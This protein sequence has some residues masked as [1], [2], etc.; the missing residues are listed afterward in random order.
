MTRAADVVVAGLGVMGSAVAAELSR[1]GLRVVGLDPH[2]P[3]HRLGSSHGETRMIRQAYSEN[4]LYVPL[5]RRAYEAW[6]ELELRSGRRLLFETGGIV[7]GFP[8]GDLVRGAEASARAHGLPLDRPDPA[9]AAERYPFVRL[10]AGHRLL[11]DPRAGYLRAEACVSAFLDL[12]RA[13]GAE[14]RTGE[15]LV[16]WSEEGP[17]DGGGLRVRTSA[18]TVPAGGLVLATGAWT[19]G[20]AAAPPMPLQPVRMVQHWFRTE[21]AGFDPADIPV[22]LVEYE[23]GKILYGFPDVG[24]GVKAAFHHGG[25]PVDPQAPRQ[26]ASAEEVEAVREVLGRHFPDARWLGVRSEP[27]LYTLTPDRHFVLDR[28]PKCRRVVVAAGFS[29]HGFKF[30]GALAGVVADLMTDLEPTFDPGPF[31]L[32]RFGS[33]P[34]VA[35]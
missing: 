3:P 32:D 25:R 14:L 2:T 23:A 29:G 20:L 1:R 8:H 18:G 22:F 19:A 4:P 34:L 6:R 15:A 21:A 33:G 31:G 27:C 9:E 24:S 28:H 10:S 5:V 35:R 11:V 16:A 30:A 7:G 26:E 12:A 17:P 13:A